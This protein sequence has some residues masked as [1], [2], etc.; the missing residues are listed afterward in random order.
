MRQPVG[1]A[2]SSPPFPPW[3]LTAYSSLVTRS[4]RERELPWRYHQFRPYP[5]ALLNIRA[6]FCRT[7]SAGSGPD[8]RGGQQSTI[9]QI[10]YGSTDLNGVQYCII[11]R[12]RQTTSLF[13]P[14]HFNSTTPKTHHST[15]TRC[16]DCARYG[17]TLVHDTSDLTPCS[18]IA[19]SAVSRR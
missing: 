14:L 13:I 12:D 3:S 1:I 18:M 8:G 7:F 11:R 17:Y 10:Q 2:I 4:L 9:K 16:C 15:T 19:F 6:L 5:L